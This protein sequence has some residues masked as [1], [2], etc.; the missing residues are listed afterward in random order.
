MH[1]KYVKYIWKGT[2]S[3]EYGKIF[4]QSRSQLCFIL[5]P[6]FLAKNFRRITSIL[7]NSTSSL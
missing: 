3:G 5:N 2:G 7:V 6:Q 1:K 4:F